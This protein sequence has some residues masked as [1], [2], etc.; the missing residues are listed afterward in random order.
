VH[1]RTVQR[2]VARAG[3][4]RLDRVVWKDQPRGPRRSPR[5]TGAEIEAQVVA[6]RRALHKE[7]DLG[8]FGADAIAAELHRQAIPNPPCA[9]TVHRILQRCGVLDG[10]QRRRRPAP[11]RGWYLPD[12]AA[13]G[14]ELDQFDL[15]QDLKIQHGPLVGSLNGVSL[16]G[17]LV[18]AFPD[19]QF[20]AEAVRGFLTEH[21]REVGLPDYVQFDNDTRFQGPHQHRDVVGSVTRLCLSLGV[22]PVFIPPGEVG[23]QAAIEN[24]N[25]LWQAK[26]WS[27]FH[28][29]SLTALQ[30]QS[31]RYVAAH[32]RRATTRRKAAPERTPFPQE[33]RLNLQTT[34]QGTIIYLRRATNQG[35]VSLL[36]RTFTVDPAWPYRLVRCEVDLDRHCIRFYALRRREPKLQPLLNELPY[37]LPHRPFE[38]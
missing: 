13:G 8:E 30:E 31:R 16:H 37:Q 25:G 1:L 17:G 11:P 36:G 19:V 18:G 7:S 14:A 22:T 33:W 6:L 15:V 21:W 5:R 24:F 4:R 26:V 29:P 9:R 32:R 28:H 34:P 2:W 10:A 3:D 12:L 23:F 27:R 35:R 20:T 38:E